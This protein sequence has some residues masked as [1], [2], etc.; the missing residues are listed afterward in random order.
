MLPLIALIYR[1]FHTN[2]KE[3]LQA[4]EQSEKEAVDWILQEEEDC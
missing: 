4:L 2:K 1:Q 3:C